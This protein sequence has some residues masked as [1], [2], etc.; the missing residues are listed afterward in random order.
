MR[1]KRRREVDMKT[2]VDGA[3]VT[4]TVDAFT[5]DERFDNE[6]QSKLIVRRV[7]SKGEPREV[8]M[9]QV[10]PGRYAADFELDGFG[11]FLLRAEHARKERDGSLR[12]VGVSFAHVSNPYPREYA[13]FEPDIE[14]LTRAVHA[15]RGEI[16]PA[17][18]QLFEPQGEQI[19]KHAELYSRFVLV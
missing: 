16:D 7:G 15:A 12:P 4:A 5:P 6:W 1:V 9:R 18:A 2:E 8:P 13:S 19:I 10:A 3:H 14:R 11:S 17:P